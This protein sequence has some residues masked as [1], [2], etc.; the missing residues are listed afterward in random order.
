MV[1]AS[2]LAGIGCVR[3]RGEGRA[4]GACMGRVIGVTGGQFLSVVRGCFEVV[5][6]YSLEK[7]IFI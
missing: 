3:K 4:L 5:F 6:I 7:V 1:A 2:R